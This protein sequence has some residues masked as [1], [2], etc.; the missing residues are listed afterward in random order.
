VGGS[1]SEP[2]TAPTI[3]GEAHR[4][5]FPRRCLNIAGWV[6]PGAV[7]ALMPK[8]PACLAAYVV[9]WT[10]FGLSLSTATHLRTSLLI[11]CVGLLLYLAV[12]RLWRSIFMKKARLSKP[13]NFAASTRGGL[14]AR[15]TAIP[16]FRHMPYNADEAGIEF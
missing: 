1:G 4:L 12:N 9:V 3:D 11:L 16:D 5:T 8:C 14:D 6:V 7:L 2:L 13:L 10:G 15:R